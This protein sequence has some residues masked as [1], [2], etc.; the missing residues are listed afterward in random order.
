MLN[1]NR[2][3]VEQM[4]KIIDYILDN[5]DKVTVEQLMAD[6]GLTF[7]EY[8]LMSALSMPAIRKKNEYKGA[9]VRAMY[10]KTA[11][12]KEKAVREKLDEMLMMVKGWLDRRFRNKVEKEVVPDGYGDDFDGNDEEPADADR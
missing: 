7:E 6:C 9:K 10:Y 2:A 5:E 8:R 11:Y 3:D 1:V 4:V 12:A